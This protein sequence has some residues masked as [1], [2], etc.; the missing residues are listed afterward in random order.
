VSE[1]IASN[2]H[3]FRGTNSARPEGPPTICKPPPW[4]TPKATTA[5]RI[6]VRELEADFQPFLADEETKHM[7]NAALLLR[8]P[9]LV[10]GS[11]GTGKTR[12]AY[13]VAHELNLGKVLRWSINTRSTLREGLYDYDAVGRLHAVTEFAHNTASES[14]AVGDF[15]KLG[16][17][18]TALLPWD[19]PRV[20][21]VDE[22]DKSHIDL[23][24]DLL[25]VFEDGQFSIPEV[26]RADEEQR[27][28]TAPGHGRVDIPDGTV[29]CFEFPLVIMT[30]NGEREFP[31]AFRRRCLELHVKQPNLE[32]LAKIVT[33]HFGRFSDGLPEGW[34]EL[35]EQFLRRR[36][37]GELAT[38][39]LM[40]AV[41]LR[42]CEVGKDPAWE[43]ILAQVWHALND[44]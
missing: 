33:E 6:E 1:A 14:V 42:A 44:T 2:W 17:L 11:P 20:V 27:F 35:C 43:Q 18:G 37:K 30:S 3:I 8:R 39:Q 23:P 25:H 12:L 38:D 41:Y 31:A 34:S 28:A 26:L 24:N 36:D 21:L 13:A 19:R 22:M 10:T 9:L 5:S 15:V 29:R 7:V 40:N 32:R 16:P 4:R